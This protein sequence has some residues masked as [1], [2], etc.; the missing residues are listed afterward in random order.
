MGGQGWAKRKWEVVLSGRTLPV[1][2][3][4][5]VQ[6]GSLEARACHPRTWGAKVGGPRVQDPDLGDA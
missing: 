2:P 1:W 5:K 6:G 3:D 4:E